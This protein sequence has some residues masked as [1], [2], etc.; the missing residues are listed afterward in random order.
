MEVRSRQDAKVGLKHR[1]GAI[2]AGE[3]L[4]EEF[5]YYLKTVALIAL[6]DHGRGGKQRSRELSL[7][8]APLSEIG[9]GW[10]CS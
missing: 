5:V 6:R 9:A 3:V 1:H 7:V 2:S 8:G 4:K 10:L